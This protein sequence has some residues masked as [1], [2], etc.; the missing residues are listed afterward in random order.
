MISVPA[1][2]RN[3]EPI[4]EVLREVF[5]AF[6]KNESIRVLEIASGGGVHAVHFA[7]SFGRNVLSW[8]PTDIE[9]SHLESIRAYTE[10]YRV[11]DS[12]KS[13]IFL[14][15]SKKYDIGDDLQAFQV[16]SGAFDF[17]FCANLIHI[18]PFDCAK[19]LFRLSG[20][21]LAKGGALLTYGP[22]SVDGVLQPESNVRFDQSL[23]YQNSEWG[24][25]DTGV[26]CAI[27]QENNMVLE[28]MHDMPA[29]NK[30]IIWRKT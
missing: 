8:Q 2:E 15:I 5:L 17:L 19:G 18:S 27:A 30:T 9:A 6:S 3:K 14:D 22:Y 21:L 4:A 26:L 20:Q 24:I 11:Q 1:A 12:V 13:P 29:N 23:R 28:K 25:R 7:E 10:K 16:K